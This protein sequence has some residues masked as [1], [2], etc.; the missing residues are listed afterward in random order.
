MST[1][2]YQ[3]S[4]Q[5]NRLQ[6]TPK[7]SEGKLKGLGKNQKKQKRVS[8][9]QRNTHNILNNNNNLPL[10]CTMCGGKFHPKHNFCG[11]CGVKREWN[12]K[13]RCVY[14]KLKKCY[15][16]EYPII[17]IFLK[18]HFIFL[19]K[20]VKNILIFKNNFFR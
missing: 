14:L 20:I 11:Y 18:Y 3:F 12:T 4:N 15:F 7:T 10:Y 5:K 17:L 19:I 1:Q 8:A 2:Q 16:Y 6:I 9:F 13:L